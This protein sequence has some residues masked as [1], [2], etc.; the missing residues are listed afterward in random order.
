MSTKH[1]DAKTDS[2]AQKKPDIIQY[3]N[4]TKGAIDT[5]DRRIASYSVKRA[6]RNW[7]EVSICNLIDLTINNAFIIYDQTN[8]GWN[9]TNSKKRIFMERLGSKLVSAQI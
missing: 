7:M 5:V 4:S 2:S 9:N 6:C 3:Y 1:H 8:K